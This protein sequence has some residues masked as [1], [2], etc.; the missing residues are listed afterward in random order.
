MSGLHYQDEWPD[1]N[2]TR[3]RKNFISAL[4]ASKPQPNEARQY[5]ERSD[6]T[7]LVFW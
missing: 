7:S 4:S 1:E 3:R 5:Q 6:R 2:S